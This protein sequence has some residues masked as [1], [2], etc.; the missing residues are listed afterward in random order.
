MKGAPCKSSASPFLSSCKLRAELQGREPMDFGGRRR[1]QK[2]A[3]WMGQARLGLGRRGT[4]PA[5]HVSS[6]WG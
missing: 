4:R 3:P 6:L 5:Q 1:G 2:M